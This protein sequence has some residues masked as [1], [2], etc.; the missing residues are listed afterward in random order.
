MENKE[1]SRDVKFKLEYWL[2]SNERVVDAVMSIGSEQAN[3]D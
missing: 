1:L 3:L 2:K